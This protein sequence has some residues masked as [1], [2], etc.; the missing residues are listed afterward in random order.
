MRCCCSTQCLRRSTI[1][2]TRRQ[3]D[4]EAVRTTPPSAAH[5]QD[6]PMRPQVPRF[7]YKKRSA[8]HNT[9]GKD[10]SSPKIQ[11]PSSPVSRQSLS[12]SAIPTYHAAGGFYEIDHDMLPPKSPIHLKSIRVVKV[13]EYTSHDITVSFPSL[14]AL[15]S[16]FSSFRVPSSGPELD[17]RFVMSS[18][19]AAR[20]LRHRVAEQEL[21]GE[22]HQDS[23]W[24]VNPCVFDFSASSGPAT[25]QDA[26][27]SPE[28]PPAPPKAP[29]V[30]S[31][32]LATLKCDGAGWGVRRRVRYIG[33][34]REVAKEASIGGYETEASVKELQRPAQEDDR[35]S[36]IRAKRKRDEAEGSKDKPGNPA[37]K[38]KSKAYKS[39]KKPKR[40]HVESRDGDPRRGK[41]RWS[42]ERY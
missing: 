12:T 3:M 33:R 17:E 36:S 28:A 37:K 15:R 9:T 27:S 41:E 2:T 38:K 16:F 42:A 39:P 7:Y 6:S 22:M 19:H 18:N 40:R 10:D 13:S 35:R 4:A 23:F 32:L 24:L 25:A 11:P 21:E 1:R 8:V 26:L 5:T 29:A 20:I 30:S 34:H 31:C 14:L